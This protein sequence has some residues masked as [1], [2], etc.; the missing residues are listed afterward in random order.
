MVISK[1]TELRKKLESINEELLR[2]AHEIYNLPESMVSDRE[3][4]KGAVGW[5]KGARSRIDD[6]IV[7]LKSVQF[8]SK[9]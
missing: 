7:D 3:G 9:Q 8:K 6:A 4:L 1:K 2:L 5:I